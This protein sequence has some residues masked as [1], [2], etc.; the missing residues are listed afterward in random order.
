[1]SYINWGSTNVDVE[2]E[3]QSDHLGTEDPLEILMAKEAMGIRLAQE[4]VA[5][6]KERNPDE[7]KRRRRCLG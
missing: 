6:R 7:Y 5:F 3:V 2:T 1:M 4:A